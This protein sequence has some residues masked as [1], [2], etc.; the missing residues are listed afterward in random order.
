MK[1][2]LQILCFAINQTKVNSTK[3]THFTFTHPFMNFTKVANVH[4]FNFIEIV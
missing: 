4:S 2:I 3:D 1:D